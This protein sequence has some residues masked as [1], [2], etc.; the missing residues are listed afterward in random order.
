MKVAVVGGGA[1]GFFAALSVKKHH[2][3]AEVVIYEKSPKTLSKVKV[4]GGGRCNVTHNE[5]NV[6]QLLKNY[7][8]GGKLLKKA[9]RQ[10]A[11]TDTIEWFKERG[12]ELHTE[13][14]NRMFPITNTSQTIIDTFRNEAERLGIK[15]FI[16]HGVSK[17]TPSEN[18]LKLSVNEQE[19]TVDK[20]ILAYGGQKRIENLTLV[21]DLGI[22]IESP[23]PSLFTFNV[24]DS[25]IVNLQGVS[26]PNALIQVQ[27][28]KLK[29]QGPVLITHWGFSG[30]AVLKTSAFGAKVLAD[31]NYNFAFKVNWLGAVNE[32]QAREKL[33]YFISQ[34]PK[35]QANKRAFDLPSRLWDW[36]ISD[37]GIKPD[38]TWNSV[39]KKSKNRLINALVNST[40]N[41]VQKTT[42]KEEFVICGGIA[43]SEMNPET[44]ALKKHPN[45]YASGELLN[46]DGVTGGFNFQAAWTTGFIAGKL[47]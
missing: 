27:G 17:I 19:V 6:P 23:V 25:T 36:L 43:L 1:S 40:F 2:P 16:K 46:I 32:E 39:D 38:I 31:N 26:V 9:F 35:K 11:V 37:A 14:D 30:P 5:F 7:P 47:N 21:T 10:F 4:S 3:K 29:E 42:F 44:M 34:N 12:V 33:Q 20:L 8:R 28:T 18:D 15:V 24:T 41:V 13:S 45:I 22:N